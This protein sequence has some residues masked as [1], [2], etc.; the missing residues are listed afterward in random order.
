MFGDAWSPQVDV[1]LQANTNINS[2]ILLNEVNACLPVLVHF[3]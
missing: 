2:I 1:Q 3:S